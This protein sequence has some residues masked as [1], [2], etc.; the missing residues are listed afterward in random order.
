VKMAIHQMLVVNEWISAD[1][2]IPVPNPT[3]QEVL[4]QVPVASEA[5][6]H[7]VVARASH[8]GMKW[9]TE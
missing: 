9:Q 2:S 6:V 5:D 4:A 1:S 7:K 3:T 8:G